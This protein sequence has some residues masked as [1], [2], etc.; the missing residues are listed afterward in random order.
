[1]AV[2]FPEAE[3]EILIYMMLGAFMALSVAAAVYIWK[4]QKF[5]NEN[6]YHEDDE[7]EFKID[8]MGLSRRAEET[9]DTVLDDSILQ[10]ELPDELNVSKATVSNAVSELFDRNLI[11]KKKK[12]NTYLI[13]PNTE[14]IRKQQR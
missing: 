7:E 9:L 10:S 11:I 12:A 1:M 8:S 14:E 13:E 5:L 6:H 4:L 3:F 2:P